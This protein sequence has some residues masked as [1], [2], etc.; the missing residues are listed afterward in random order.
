MTGSCQCIRWP[1]RSVPVLVVVLSLFASCLLLNWQITSVWAQDR[2][3]Q[4][5]IQQDDQTDLNRQIGR[6]RTDSPRQTLE[7]FRRLAREL[8]TALQV[9]QAEWSFDAAARVHRTVDELRTLI[10]LSSV[11]S[12]SRRYVG[13]GATAY[14]LDIFS[15][16]ELPAMED[17]PDVSADPKGALS[18]YRIPGTP[19]RITRIYKGERSGEY[20]FGSR[21]YDIAK[22]L[23]YDLRAS[24][25]RNRSSIE[26]WGDTIP[27]LTG[28]LIPRS[29]A[30]SIPDSLKVT[31]FDT[32]LWKLLAAGILMGL[33]VLILVY[34]DRGLRHIQTEDRTTR[35]VLDLVTPITLLAVLLLLDYF[36][37]GQ[38]LMTGRSQRFLDL[39]FILVF[40]VTLAWAFWYLVLTVFEALVVDPRFQDQSLDANMFRLIARIL[41]VVG[42]LLI[43]AYGLQTL[44]VPV[45]SLIA[46]LGIGGLAIAL[47]IRPTLENLIGGF[48][49]FVDKPVRVG[50]YCSFGDK[51]GTVEKIGVR[52]TQVRSVDRTL[53]SIPNSQFV[54]MQL[55]NWARCDQMMITHT[56]GLRYETEPDQLRYVLAKIREMF[57][58]HPRID[59]DTIRVR[60]TGYGASSLDIDVRVYAKTREWND[61]YAIKEDVLLR[62]AEIVKSAGTGFAFPSRTLYLRKDGG[63]DEKLGEK[64]EQEVKDWRRKRAF[65]FPK[66][67]ASKLE[68]LRDS[69]HYPPRGSPDFLATEEELSEGGE[70]LSAEPVEEQIEAIEEP[71]ADEMAQ[72][73][74]EETREK[75]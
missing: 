12:A 58:S 21:T 47:A 41:A 40:F 46:G 45:L 2:P 23:S 8:E 30:Q 63:L 52:S 55:I 33:A 60:F 57:H 54:D 38:L 43:L 35:L 65:P 9:Y 36:L 31:V 71:S 73:L 69:L 20:L 59:S 10:D 27:Q 68:K 37:A 1:G 39:S 17:V 22:R 16:I 24:P 6:Y 13:N 50:D 74:T 42:G 32:P 18:S 75:K 53:I 11:P 4:T 25:V 29:V 51:Q 66:F 26:S 3:A 61:F 14:L 48:V 5:S 7:T 28:P 70:Q 44:G 62:I 34:G 19:L 67:A 49:L 56:L 64:A 15:R 72:P